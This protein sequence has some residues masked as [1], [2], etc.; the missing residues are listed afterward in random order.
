MAILLLADSATSLV[1]L[2]ERRALWTSLTAAPAAANTALLCLLPVVFPAGPEGRGSNDLYEGGMLACAKAL[3]FLPAVVATGCAA[4][5]VHLLDTPP[6]IERT[7]VLALENGDELDEVT[8]NLLV[9]T[10]SLSDAVTSALGNHRV[11]G[12]GARPWADGPHPDTAWRPTACDV[13]QK[14]SV[15]TMASVNRRMAEAEGPKPY[16]VHKLLQAQEDAR[17]IQA[18]HQQ[19]AEADASAESTS[20]PPRSTSKL[21][22]AGR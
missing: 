10:A 15:E 4:T 12:A 5:L 6:L 9:N 20:T 22:A 2:L 1:H 21:D 18:A 7:L 17:R 13:K 19:Q 11:A 16:P 14:G 3:C 8:T